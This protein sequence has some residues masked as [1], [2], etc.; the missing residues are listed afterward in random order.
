[1]DQIAVVKTVL[2]ESATE[3]P[4]ADMPAAP[5]AGQVTSAV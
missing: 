3:A 1:V 5:A 2:R 4:V